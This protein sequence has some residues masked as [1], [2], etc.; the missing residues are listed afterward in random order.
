MGGDFNV[1]NTYR[2]SCHFWKPDVKLSQQAIQRIGQ[3]T[4][5][6]HLIL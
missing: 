6:N 3:Q 1:K 4:E 2:V 5:V